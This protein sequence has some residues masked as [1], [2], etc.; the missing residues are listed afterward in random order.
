MAGSKLDEAVARI[1]G[2]ADVYCENQVYVFPDYDHENY[3]ATKVCKRLGIP[4]SDELFLRYP[5]GRTF[6][7]LLQKSI[8]AGERALKAKLPADYKELLRQFG[9]FHLPG[10]EVICFD[11]PEAAARA[12]RGCWIFEGPLT[13]LAISSYHKTADGDSIG[14][15]RTG[16]MFGDDLFHF[17]HELRKDGSD[18]RQW[19]RKIASS[20]SEFIVGHLDSLGR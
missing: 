2:V 18:P 7:P 4:V 13:A 11:G 15:L 17:Q 14:F 1:R 3:D 6:K 10:E 9:E 20:L 16:E 19:S 12:T 5:A 8:E